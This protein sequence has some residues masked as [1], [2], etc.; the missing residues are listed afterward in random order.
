MC[1]GKF[2]NYAKYHRRYLQVH[3]FRQ[4]FLPAFSEPLQ[5]L[6]YIQQGQQK[7]QTELHACVLAS[8]RGS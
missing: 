5:L 1:V 7:V 2:P 6:P 4:S 8:S 3:L